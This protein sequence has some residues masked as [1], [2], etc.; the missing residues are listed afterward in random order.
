MFRSLVI[1]ASFVAVASSAAAQ[2]L[3][4]FRWQT[5]PYCNVLTLTVTQQ[6]SVYALDG[7]DDQCGGAA[8]ATASGIAVPNPDGT[9]Q[10]GVTVVTAPGG[11]PVH[12]TAPLDTRTFTG[13]WTDNGG[14]SGT[15]AFG[16]N[17]G[18][19]PRP[20]PTPIPPS[21]DLRSDSSIVARGTEAPG[22]NPPISRSTRFLWD[23]GKGAFRAGGIFY[24]TED[25]EIGR[26]SVAFGLGARAT[27]VSSF[28]VASGTAAGASSIALGCCGA[29]GDG[30][31][32]IGSFAGAHGRFSL[33]LGR[34]SASG[35]SSVAIGSDAYADHAGAIVLGDASGNSVRSSA[36]N[37]LTARVGGGVRFFS[38]TLMTTGVTLAP[39]ASAWASLS[40]ANSKEHF[41]ELDG[42]DVLEK[43]AR[44][45]IQEWNYKAQDA[46]IRHVGPTAQDFHAAF[47]L[48]EDPLRISTIDA[49]GIAL[50]AIQALEARTR[51]AMDEL[52]RE[53]AELRRENAD[54][55]AVISALQVRLDTLDRQRD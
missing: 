23:A 22:P 16:A 47:G 1:L 30:S 2:P 26:F 51:A 29:M 20:I 13:A 39:N 8:H 45:P 10:L 52:R 36:A 50:R 48:G 27:G 19:H 9:I 14:N 54:L 28:A 34:A 42:A 41:R 15:L 53:T 5:Q 11:R 38:N 37:Q 55:R 21:I 43:L 40:D 32:A 6:G 33:A 17:T 7:F 18:G 25:D 31:V 46:S 3:G 49:D 12:I 44:M 24:G 35:V 4:T